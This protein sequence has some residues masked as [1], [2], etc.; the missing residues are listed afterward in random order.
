M[1]YNEFPGRSHFPKYCAGLTFLMTRDIIPELYRASFS[2]P[3]F[4]IDDVY[5]TGLLPPKVKDIEYIDLLKN[6]TLKETPAYEEY[7]ISK[8]KVTHIFAHVKKATNFVKMWNATLTRLPAEQLK[9]L[10][11]VVLNEYPHLWKKL[12]EAQKVKVAR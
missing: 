5:A 6:F 8:E 3:F 9:T 11:D 12:D 4:W 10:S 2:T 1:K 7:V